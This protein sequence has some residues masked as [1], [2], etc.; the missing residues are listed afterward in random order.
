MNAIFNRRS[1]RK[2][3]KQEISDETIETL[4]RAAMAAPSAGNQQPW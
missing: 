2:F 1:I 3:T 4:L